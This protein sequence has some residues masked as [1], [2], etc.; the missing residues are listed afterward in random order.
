MSIKLIE[1]EI[2]RFLA[3]KEPEV[4][5]VS[6]RWGVGKTFAWNQNLRDAQANDQIALES[7]SYVS[8]FG[9][10]SLEELK[11][12]IFENSVKS[13]EIGV[14]LSLDALQSQTTAAAKQLGKKSLGV[15]QQ[16][17]ALRN[18]LG[19]L[20]A[21]WF[22]LVR[23]T[24]ICIDDMERRGKNLSVREV[25]GL[26]SNLRE[27]KGCKVALILNDEALEEDKE[28]FKKYLEK[29]VD[30]SLKFEPS[31]QECA[32]IALP[33]DGETNKLLAES[34]VALGISN[35]RLIKRIERSMRQVEAMLK[36]FDKQVLKQAVQSLA[37]LGW[38][39][40]EPAR[41]PSLDYL[42]HRRGPD[43][44]GADKDE[45][46]PA[47]EAA[48]NAL[49]DDYGFSGMDEFDLVLLEGIRN[50]F[51]DSSLLEKRASP[52]NNQIKAA[53]LS[54]AFQDAWRMFHDSF[55]DN[56]EQVLNA[57]YQSFFEGV[58]YI[59]P[60]NLSGT[61][62][63][64]K[65]LGRQE[66]A[67]AIIKHYVK[68]HGEDREFFDLNN[69]PFGGDVK[70]PDVVRAFSEKYATFK[71][72]REITTTLLS[73]ANMNGWSEKDIVTLST[74]PVEEYY[75]LFKKSEGRDLRRIINACLQFDNIM[76]ATEQM[77]RISKR[78]KDA[79]RRIGQESEINARRVKRYGIEVRVPP[80]S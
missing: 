61:V 27:L 14:E 13:S 37:L 33:K 3:T 23:K 19:G 22:S 67:A 21:V 51:F 39:V 26:V 66:Q 44:F 68:S 42:Q 4:I 62:S 48:W 64:F 20:G 72:E 56:Q 46:V 32:S 35:I 28:E 5:C 43:I 55:A 59:T 9:V 38:S 71:V 29:V 2:R 63:L 25:L 79:L 17:P 11:Y 15:I 30:T 10:N 7:Y 41:A 80:S 53:K 50:G 36:G 58:Q 70:D 40:Y 1:N 49:L 65:E 6:G 73:M 69:Y 60:V 8:L 54:T 76:N 12:S 77:K 18:Y 24:I 16:V 47:N 75:K 78:A 57:I 45:V 52:L 34:C 31:A 74:M